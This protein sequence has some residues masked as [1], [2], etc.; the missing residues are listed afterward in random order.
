MEIAP[1]GNGEGESCDPGTDESVPSEPL[2]STAG[3]ETTAW[4]NAASVGASSTARTAASHNDKTPSIIAAAM[5]PKTKASGIAASSRRTERPA[6]ERTTRASISDASV[7][8]RI[9]S[10]AFNTI[11]AEVSSISSETTP[12]TC[13]LSRSPNPTITIS[14]VKM[15]AVNRSRSVS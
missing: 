3:L 4:P 15:L 6:S 12:S 2:R 7:N 1:D 8:R 11:C 5:V 9:T 10:V 14:P 13:E